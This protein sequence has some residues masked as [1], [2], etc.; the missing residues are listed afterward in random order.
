M[1]NLSRFV[2]V[3]YPVKKSDFKELYQMMSVA[4]M[5]AMLGVGFTPEEVDAYIKR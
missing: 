4:M 3:F 5:N 2:L 1:H